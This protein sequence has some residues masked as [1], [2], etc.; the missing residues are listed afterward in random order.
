[1][2]IADAPA[3]LWLALALLAGAGLA[4]VHFWGLWLTVRALPGHRHPGRLLLASVAAR[5]VVALGAF[6]VLV[7]AGGWRAAVAALTG[8]LLVRLL[9][10]RRVA[11]RPG[12][13][14][15]AAP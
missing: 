10:V 11:L 14:V 7:R 6:L 4:A 12:E 13:D 8:F 3:W 1:M 15:V 5:F 2:T 9:V